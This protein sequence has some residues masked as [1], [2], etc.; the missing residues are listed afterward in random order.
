MTERLGSHA[1]R[2]LSSS[3]KAWFEQALPV[4][5]RKP[6]GTA[7]DA[8]IAL[9]DA[10]KRERAYAPDP[11]ALRHLAMRA[12]ELLPTRSNAPGPSSRPRAAEASRT[13]V[14]P[15][16][17]AP[18]PSRRSAASRTPA[19]RR[20]TPEEEE[21]DEIA[22]LERELA[23]LAEHERQNAAAAA[24][25]CTRGPWPRPRFGA[26]GRASAAVGGSV[27]RPDVHRW[28]VRRGRRRGPV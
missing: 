8:Q 23:R 1:Q 21:A 22:F 5:A 13:F 17:A 4:D 6:L 24:A 11:I 28:S 2:P 7:I 9:E 16:A 3:M 15:D 25:A 14:S 12:I 19:V 18:A 10:V 27:A 20:Q 26:G